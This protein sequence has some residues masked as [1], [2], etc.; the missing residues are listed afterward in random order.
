VTKNLLSVLDPV[1][2]AAIFYLVMTLNTYMHVYLLMS[3]FRESDKDIEKKPQIFKIYTFLFIIVILYLLTL[4][5]LTLCCH[6]YSDC[7]MIQQN[8]GCS[9]GQEESSGGLMPLD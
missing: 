2:D 9:H 6:C 7:F 1:Q 3:T 8:H 5:H 4:V